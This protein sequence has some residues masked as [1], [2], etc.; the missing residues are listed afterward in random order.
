M[1]LLVLP[2]FVT[3]LALGVDTWRWR[4]IFAVATLLS[5]RFL[6]PAWVAVP[7]TLIVGIAFKN[8]LDGMRG[9]SMPRI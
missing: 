5:M 1:S 6:G 2:I 7:V 4:I 3:S 9:S 8:S